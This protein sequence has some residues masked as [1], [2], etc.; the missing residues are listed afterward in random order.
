MFSDLVK[1]Q[2]ETVRGKSFTFYEIGS[3]VW[4]DHVMTEEEPD[5]ERSAKTVSK[6]NHSYFCRVIAASMLPGVD[7]AFDELVADLMPLPD[8]LISELFVHADRVNGLSEKFEVLQGK[9]SPADDT[10]AD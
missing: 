10:P 5:Q 7:K 8:E 1:Q 3:P 9:A 2:T 6:A 4:T